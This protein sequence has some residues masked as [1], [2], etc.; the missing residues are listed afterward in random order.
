HDKLT[1]LIIPARKVPANHFA[2]DRK[3]APVWA[4]GALDSWPLTHAPNPFVRASRR[5]ARL[6]GFSALET[7]RI[8]IGSPTKERA[9]EFDLGGR[10]RIIPDRLPDFI[11][12]ASFLH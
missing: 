1:A 5:V 8:N 6:S 9:K 4:I 7:A 10:R 12:T 3:E 11:G 2:G